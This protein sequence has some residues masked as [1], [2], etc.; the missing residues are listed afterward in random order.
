MPGRRKAATAVAVIVDAHATL[1]LN[2]PPLCDTGCL[3]ETYDLAD[4]V[5]LNILDPIGNLLVQSAGTIIVSPTVI[6]EPASALLLGG[7]L[8]ALGARRKLRSR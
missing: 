1:D 5:I 2:S 8:L 6:P 4:D 7:G 3:L